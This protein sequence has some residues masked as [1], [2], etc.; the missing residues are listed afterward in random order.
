MKLFFLLLFIFTLFIFVP[1]PFKF[2]IHFS[3]QDYYIKLYGFSLISKE[4]AN[5]KKNKSST[6]KKSHH[7]K[8]KKKAVDSRKEILFSKL[9]KIKYKDLISELYERRFKPTIYI[10]A[11]L[12]YSLEDAAKTALLYGA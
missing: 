6:K 4:K 12:N 2:T 8:E 1:I 3:S 5:I 10:D 7:F 9:K 11:H